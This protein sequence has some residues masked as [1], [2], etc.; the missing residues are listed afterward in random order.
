[1]QTLRLLSAMHLRAPV[2]TLSD[3]DLDHLI[4][5]LLKHGIRP[6]DAELA[7]PGGAQ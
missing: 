2:E 4:R 3:A 1:M 5:T 6:E 7:L